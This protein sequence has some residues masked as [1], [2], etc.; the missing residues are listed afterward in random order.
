V[1]DSHWPHRVESADKSFWTK[2][3]GWGVLDV[4]YGGST[5]SGRA[6]AGGSTVSG[7]WSMWPMRAAP[8]SGGGR[9][10]ASA[11]P[12]GDWR[13]AWPARFACWGALFQSPKPSA[14]GACRYGV[15]QIWAAPWLKTPHRFEAHY[16]R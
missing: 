12:G 10:K 1:D 6:S 13:G 8:A 5:A 2:P 3:I 4:N 14:R 9:G 15:G 11:A 7:A 16:H